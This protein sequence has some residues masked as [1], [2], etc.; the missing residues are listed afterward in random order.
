MDVVAFSP[1]LQPAATTFAAVIPYRAHAASLPRKTDRPF[2]PHRR[3]RGSR[4]PVSHRTAGRSRG[5]LSGVLK[6]GTQIAG[7]RILIYKEAGVRPPTFHRSPR[8]HIPLRKT[9]N[10]EHRRASPLVELHPKLRNGL[11]GEKRLSL[12]AASTTT[13]VETSPSLQL[14]PE[15]LLPSRLHAPHETVLNAG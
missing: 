6:S 3:W 2:P 14:N 1:L 4:K 10:P 13:R 8:R 11:R 9:R 5:R 7:Q 12:P 15:P